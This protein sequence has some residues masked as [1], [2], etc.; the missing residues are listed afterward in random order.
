MPPLTLELELPEINQILSLLG[1][2]PYRNVFRLIAK[3][4]SQANA[5]IDPSLPPAE[6]SDVAPSQPQLAGEDLRHG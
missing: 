5:Q 1:E 2:Q 6:A 4:Q 3:I